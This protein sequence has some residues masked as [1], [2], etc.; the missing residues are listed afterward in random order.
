MS[1][2][3]LRARALKRLDKKYV[4][5]YD[6][7][8]LIALIQ[9]QSFFYLNSRCYFDVGKCLY[10]GNLNTCEFFVHLSMNE[11]QGWIYGLISAAFCI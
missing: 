5:K 3:F 1:L 9:K 6:I 11:T 10:I 2:G 7:S 4:N 8:A